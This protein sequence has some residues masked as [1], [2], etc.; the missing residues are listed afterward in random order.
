MPD[1]ELH[2]Y[3][4]DGRSEFGGGMRDE[5]RGRLPAAA[6]HQVFFH[7][8]VPV[9][10]LL[11]ALAEAR[12]AVFPSYAEAFAHAPLE[13]MAVGCP[14]VY[15]CRGS[16]PELITPESDGL[17]VDPDDRT[18][19]ATAL[20]RLLTDDELARRLGAAGRATIAERF[21]ADRLVAASTRFYA[22]SVERF[23]ARRAS[24]AAGTRGGRHAL[25]G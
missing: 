12:A 24:S 3:G 20:V 23:Q 19:I 1:A 18:A 8:H 9:D 21:S 4:K 2:L 16:G 13:A 7:G 14:T 15:T 22:S 10:Q 6:A 17:L 5:L 25:A 11:G